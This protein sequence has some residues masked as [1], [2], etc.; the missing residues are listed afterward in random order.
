RGLAHLSVRVVAGRGWRGDPLTAT[1]A[2]V[3]VIFADRRA[4]TATAWNSERP[5]WGQRL[6]LGQVR[7]RP[8]AHL[9]LQVWDEDHGWDDD[10][11]GTCRWPLTAGEWPERSCFAGSG[12]LDF[13]VT[14]RCGPALAGSLC[15]DYRPAA[16]P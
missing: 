1:D 2:Y 16:P 7:L 3:W 13:A 11:L 6:E 9:E 12:R 14:A 8:D 15:H 10:H 5:L 4:R